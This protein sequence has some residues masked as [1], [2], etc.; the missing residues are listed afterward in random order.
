MKSYQRNYAATRP[1]M[2]D[3][4]SRRLRAIRI[5]KTLSHFYGS[6]DNLSELKA[7]DV[8]SSTGIIDSILAKNFK[9]VVGSDIDRKA[10][11][12]AQKKFKQKNLR[13]VVE[14][15][16]KLSFKDENFDVVICAQVYEHVPDPKKLLSEIYRVLKKR[17]S[18]LFCCPKRSL[19][20]RTAS[21]FTIL[22]VSAKIFG[23][24][25]CENI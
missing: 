12:F 5:I 21:S 25:L 24:F 13:F 15:A 8:G 19:A 9:E 4:P 16:M 14:D 22:V 3:L 23:K 10:V 18:L 11:Y 2:Y 6:L 7:L 17:W 1:Q 20:Y